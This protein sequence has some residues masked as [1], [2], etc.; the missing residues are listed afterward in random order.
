M[1]PVSPMAKVEEGCKGAKRRYSVAAVEL[2]ESRLRHKRQV[3][4]KARGLRV[5]G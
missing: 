5:Q 3:S 2:I 4:D 1:T